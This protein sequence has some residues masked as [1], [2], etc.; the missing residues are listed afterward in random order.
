MGE[1]ILFLMEVVE[2][3]NYIKDRCP[4]DLV[5]DSGHSVSEGIV[6]PRDVPNSEIV[7]GDDSRDNSDDPIDRDEDDEHESDIELLYAVKLKAV[8]LYRKYVA[9][10]AELEVN[11]SYHCRRQLTK[12]MGTNEVVNKW[13]SDNN[14]AAAQFRALSGLYEESCT[15]IFALIIDSFNRFKRT[16]SYA[17]LRRF[18]IFDD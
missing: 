5:S 9:P 11:L 3:Q 15:Q 14:N 2:F 16:A 4:Y 7:H 8:K 1:S 13:L 18:K 10:H 17:Q 6:F 12:L